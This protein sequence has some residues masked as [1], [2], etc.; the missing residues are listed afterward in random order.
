MLM[1]IFEPLPFILAIC[2]PPLSVR[3]SVEETYQ[4][5]LNILLTLLGGYVPGVIHA[6][7]LTTP[8]CAPHLPAR[9][10]PLTARLRP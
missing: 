9:T 10:A 4:V 5:W 3:L 6:L 8:P 7:Y 1:P 2:C